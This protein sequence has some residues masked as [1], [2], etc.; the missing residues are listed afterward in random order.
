MELA[1]QLY[2]LIP[3]IKRTL[4]RAQPKYLI[5]LRG[6][7]KPIDCSDSLNSTNCNKLLH[8]GGLGTITL[9]ET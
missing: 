2:S 6:W 8:T 1:S 3:L 9:P 7:G 4:G 5:S